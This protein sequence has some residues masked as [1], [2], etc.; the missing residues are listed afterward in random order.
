MYR[1]EE[2]CIKMLKFPENW[3]VLLKITTFIE[4]IVPPNILNIEYF[5]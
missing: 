2:N 4:S 1:F 5:Y 3:D